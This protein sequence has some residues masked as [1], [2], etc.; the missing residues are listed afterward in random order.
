M[1][2]LSTPPMCPTVSGSVAAPRTRYKEK[3]GCHAN[4]VPHQTRAQGERTDISVDDRPL[5]CLFAICGPHLLLAGGPRESGYPYPGVKERQSTPQWVSPG[6]H[7]TQGV[8]ATQKH[9][10]PGGLMGDPFSL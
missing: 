4:K 1:E 7:G 10:L 8:H 5:S 3:L 9:R 6:W 2:C